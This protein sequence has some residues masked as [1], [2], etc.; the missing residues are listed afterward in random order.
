MK[1]LLML[2]TLLALLYWLTKTNEKYCAC[3]AA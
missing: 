1:D 2:I 3:G